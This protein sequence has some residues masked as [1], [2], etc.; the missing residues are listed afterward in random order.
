[1]VIWI[2]GLSGSGKTT[3]LDKVYE[4]VHL[5]VNNLVKID[6]DIIREVFA[7]DLGHT[8][9]HRK[10]NAKRI[11]K[12][13]QFLEK[14]NIIVVCSILSVFEADR[15]WNRSNLKNYKEIY[16]KTPQENLVDRDS[17]GLYKKHIKGEINNVVGFDITFEEPKNSDLVIH[18]NESKEEF[19]KNSKFISNL[20]LNN[21]I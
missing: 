11:S 10:R 6:G 16:I 17:K 5:K 8:I 19:L 12:L 13:S 15:E 7:N 2:I 4:D 9:E 21:D 14:Q 18:N 1:M 3:L 20:I